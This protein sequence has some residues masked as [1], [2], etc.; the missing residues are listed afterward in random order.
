[1]PLKLEETE[2]LSVEFLY[3][4][5][6]TLFTVQTAERTLK[7]ALRYLGLGDPPDWSAVDAE[8]S[9]NYKSPIG[10]LLQKL[11][12]RATV[13]PEFSQVL[14]NFLSKRNTFVHHFQETYR[15]RTP[16]DR[17]LAIAFLKSLEGDAAV[18][19]VVLQAA[20]LEWSAHLLGDELDVRIPPMV[21]RILPTLD[22]HVS[23]RKP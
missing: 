12:Q 21:A 17:D 3:W 9:V 11:R 6:R 20:A 19:I 8:Q 7:A 14:T 10:P 1:M 16:E 13:A 2:T 18:T 22:Q 15:I 4:M 5:G 23:R